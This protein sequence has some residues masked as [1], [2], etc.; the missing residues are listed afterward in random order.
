MER[1]YRQSG[2]MLQD[3]R[4]KRDLTQEEVVEAVASMESEKN[5]RY[6]DVRT[7]R[8]YE[9]GELR[10]SRAALVFTVV[11]V[12][13]E[14]D[15]RIVNRIL[16]VADYAALSSEEISR[17]GLSHEEPVPQKT[18]WG[19][20]DGMAAGIYISSSGTGKFI[21]F[22]E[23]K[24]EIETRLFNQLGEHIPLKCTAGLS[25]SFAISRK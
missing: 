25:L 18:L 7:L 19:P 20:N 23:A 8:R 4:L 12:L 11:A 2:T 9:S 5:H 22:D 3:L 10:P 14:S 13:K 24:P 6:Y 17:Y 16:Q 21:P 15:A 1:P